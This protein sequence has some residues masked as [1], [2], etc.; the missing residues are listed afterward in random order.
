MHQVRRKAVA[1]NEVFYERFIVVSTAWIE[2]VAAFC[3]ARKGASGANENNVAAACDQCFSKCCA[4]SAIVEIEQP[5]LFSCFRF[6]C[7][8]FIEPRK[9]WR[10]GAP[11]GWY[12]EPFPD[13]LS[14]SAHCRGRSFRQL[15]ALCAEAAAFEGIGRKCDAPVGLAI[16]KR[17]PIDFDTRGPQT[18]E[19]GEHRLRIGD[20][21]VGMRQRRKQ[22]ARVSLGKEAAHQG[23]ERAARP[24]FEKCVVLIFQQFGN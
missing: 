19:H 7:F 23:G 14:F 20:L 12:I 22:V 13:I 8:R 11:P 24:N 17:L 3:L 5:A 6:G 21:I 18:A 15:W 2:Y 10:S 1:R 4:D 9:R 16:L